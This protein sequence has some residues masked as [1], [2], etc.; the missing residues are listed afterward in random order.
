MLFAYLSRQGASAEADV[1]INFQRFPPGESVSGVVEMARRRFAINIRFWIHAFYMFL[2]IGGGCDAKLITRDLSVF[3]RNLA[4]WVCAWC[5]IR[6]ASAADG[7]PFKTWQ[8][9]DSMTACVFLIKTAGAALGF[10]MGRTHTRNLRSPKSVY[11][12][13]SAAYIGENICGDIA[14]APWSVWDVGKTYID[15]LAVHVNWC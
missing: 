11:P 13:M 2:Y 10:L 9:A 5:S 7:V 15:L 8:S 12:N 1:E 4:Y 6:N 3:K 14:R